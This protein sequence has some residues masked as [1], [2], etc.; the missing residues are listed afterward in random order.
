[1]LSLPTGPYPAALY[2]AWDRAGEVCLDARRT[3]AC[4]GNTWEY[5]PGARQCV[6]VT[7]SRC[8]AVN[9][10]QAKE[11]CEK[12]CAGEGG[13]G[14]ETAGKLWRYPDSKVHGANMG[15]I[16]GRQDP[17]GPHVGPMNFVIWVYVNYI[18]GIVQNCSNPI[19]LA[20]GSLQSC[21]TP[22]I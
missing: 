12:T 1:M 6:Q 21:P 16:C 19:A 8:S 14:E 13:P 5:S 7:G 11:D 10:Y 9:K 15:P 4:S 20:M 2:K 3:V 18:D 22:L 17:G